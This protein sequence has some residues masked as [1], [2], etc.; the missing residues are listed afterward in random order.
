MQS[1]ANPKINNFF[2]ILYNSVEFKSTLSSPSWV[3]VLNILSLSGRCLS[4]SFNFMLLLIF[5][6]THDVDLTVLRKISES[7][8]SESVS[9]LSTSPPES[10]LKIAVWGPSAPTLLYNITLWYLNSLVAFQIIGI[11]F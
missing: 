8:M 10:S 3:Q 6:A 9:I 7:K 5:H 2:Y 4:V 11:S 1:L